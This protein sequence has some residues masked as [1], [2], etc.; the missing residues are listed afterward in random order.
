MEVKEFQPVIVP[1]GFS[2]QRTRIPFTVRVET[3]DLSPPDAQGLILI[4]WY[5]DMPFVCITAGI[6]YQP[7]VRNITLSQFVASVIIQVEIIE[8]NITDGNKR[9]GLRIIVPEETQRLGIELGTPS[10]LN[11]TVVDD[12]GM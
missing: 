6:D 7:L 12:D 4:P 11:V 3:F 9:F 5:L 1:V 8:N 10:E 2:P